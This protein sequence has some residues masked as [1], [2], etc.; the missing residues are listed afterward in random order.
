MPAAQAAPDAAGRFAPAAPRVQSYAERVAPLD[1]ARLFA[2][3]RRAAGG[4]CYWER[5]AER[6]VFVGIGA[7]ARIAIEGGRVLSGMRA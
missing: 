4:A 5:P 1:P 3:G 6:N 7:A 2:L